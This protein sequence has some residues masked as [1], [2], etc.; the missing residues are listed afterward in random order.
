M[1]SERAKFWLSIIIIL[2]GIAIK[3]IGMREQFYGSQDKERAILS[4][5]DFASDFEKGENRI[6]WG[7]YIYAFGMG[8][9][10]GGISGMAL[11]LYNINK[12]M[13]K[14]HNRNEITT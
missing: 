2:I 9:I 1:L 4:D 13:N 6:E 5:G 11:L 7:G 8:L 3:D 14:K 12:K 10:C